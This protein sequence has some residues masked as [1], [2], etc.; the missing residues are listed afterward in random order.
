MILRTVSLKNLKE[1]LRSKLQCTKTV[2]YLTRSTI[3]FNLSRHQDGLSKLDMHSASMTSSVLLVHCS[4][5]TD[6]GTSVHCIS[7]AAEFGTPST[8]PHLRQIPGHR[9]NASTTSPLRIHLILLTSIW[10]LL[11]EGAS[12]SII[13]SE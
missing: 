4:L 11:Y 5:E 7:S 12:C 10:I 8:Y 3:S 9:F 1:M 13:S 2:L 6:V